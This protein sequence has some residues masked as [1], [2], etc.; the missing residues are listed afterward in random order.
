MDA[1]NAKDRETNTASVGSV[2]D[3]HCHWQGK[4]TEERHKWRESLFIAHP[5]V[6]FAI[7]GIREKAQRVA[8]T[9]ESEGV[10]VLG[11]T[12]SGKT[13][14]LEFLSREF[15]IE[16][17]PTLDYTPRP[18]VVL[19]VPTPCSPLD[20]SRAVLK[21]LGD[22]L[23]HRVRNANASDRVRGLLTDCKV[24]FLAIDNF[25]DVPE[26]R[27]T[28]GVDQVITWVRELFDAV[29]AV[30]L[31]VGN[32]EA[33]TVINSS[34]Q[35]K[36]RFPFQCR[37][38]YQGVETEQQ[39]REFAKLL[40]EIARRLPLAEQQSFVDHG[41]VSRAFY[42]TSGIIKYLVELFDHAWT[43]GLKQGREQLLVAD[44]EAAFVAQH[45]QVPEGCNPFAASFEPRLLNKPGEPFHV[46]V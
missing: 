40:F 44:F 20:F 10:V 27:R 22:P 35:L 45:G 26:R 3:G 15:A 16:P 2:A 41:F 25:H 19:S 13:H 9:G 28:R 5:S 4:S 46:L 17:D 23:R 29:P 24:K 7:E 33:D 14:M 31:L 42:G 12:G 32:G 39:R 6:R 43:L 1:M 30:Y 11:E 36:R 18:F 37:L 8:R 38:Q 34:T 21:S